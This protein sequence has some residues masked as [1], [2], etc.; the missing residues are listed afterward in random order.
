[1]K[2]FNVQVCCLWLASLLCI[3]P[4]LVN[5]QQFELFTYEN[6]E[7][8]NHVAYDPA[9]GRVWLSEFEPNN[10]LR[11]FEN[12]T[13]TVVPEVSGYITD[14][15][16]APNGD[17]WITT[18]SGTYQYSNGTVTHFTKD[19][20][21]ITEGTAC[22]GFAGDL[23]YVGSNLGLYQ[24]DG[25]DWV[26]IGDFTTVRS[27]E[28]QENTGSIFVGTLV[29]LFELKANGDVIHIDWQVSNIP[30]ADILD[31]K[32][33]NLG[34]LWLLS[35]ESGI[36]KYDGNTFT[37]YTKENTGFL[38]NKI[39]DLNID[40]NNNVWLGYSGVPYGISRFDGVECKNY[41]PE[42]SDYPNDKEVRCSV[43][44]GN[45]DIWIGVDSG[46]LRLSNN[47]NGLKQLSTFSLSISPNPVS[48]VL[49]IQ[50]TENLA[51]DVYVLNA[52]GRIMAAQ[53][54]ENELFLDVQHYPKGMYYLTIKND[55][56]QQTESFIVQ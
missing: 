40:D 9:T 15:D 13:F 35:F 53:S 27:I 46:L 14:M 28:F 49:H 4:F 42:N 11:Y 47:V 30:F 36:A 19:N 5:G 56:G 32:F 24:Y 51:G 10:A 48:N 26:E 23:V 55:K 8:N 44:G 12:G 37:H 45:G 17:L 50:S 21:P 52:E 34:N 16:I 38:K 54:F 22:V 31:L 39:S 18:F 1:M 3:F 25:K 2:H 41:T 20:S 33:D 6:G 43:P 29:Y 7:S